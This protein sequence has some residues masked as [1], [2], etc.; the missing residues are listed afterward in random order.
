[1]RC[2]IG[3]PTTAWQSTIL[4]DAAAFFQLL[5]GSLREIQCSEAELT[6]SVLVLQ[7]VHGVALNLRPADGHRAAHVGA[8]RSSRAR[9]GGTHPAHSPGR[10]HEDTSDANARDRHVRRSGVQ[11]T[12]GRARGKQSVPTASRRHIDRRQAAG[13]S[14][15][16]TAPGN[17]ASKPASS[18][19]GRS[20]PRVRGPQSITRPTRTQRH[21]QA[22]NGTGRY[23]ARLAH[24]SF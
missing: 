12:A 16:W 6:W 3:I 2:L 13:R 8:A 9:E 15:P 5:A 1:M 21:T 19:R 18:K 22:H 7:A 17:G 14:P 23:A 20:L 11:H 24:P 10:G 4:C